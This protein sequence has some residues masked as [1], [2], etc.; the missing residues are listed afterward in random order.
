MKIY[1][2]GRGHLT[3]Q[4]STDFQGKLFIQSRP[5]PIPLNL[6]L[7][8]SCHTSYLTPISEANEGIRK[9]K[10]KLNI[11]FFI[12]AL[13]SSISLKLFF[14]EW[15]KLIVHLTSRTV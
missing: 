7:S 5:I 13:Y 6:Y 14:I 2:A 9:P 3:H 1:D 10:Q 12:D 11:Y 4:V 15:V 8:L